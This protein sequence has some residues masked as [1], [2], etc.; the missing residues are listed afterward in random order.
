MGQESDV[1]GLPLSGG[2]ALGSL[3]TQ[4]PW[5]GLQRGLSQKHLPAS[6]LASLIII[7]KMG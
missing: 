7:C 2:T 6:Y 4:A 1:G 3:G 5:S